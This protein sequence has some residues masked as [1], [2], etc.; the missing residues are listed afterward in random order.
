ME[1]EVGGG[2]LEGVSVGADEDV[3]GKGLEDGLVASMTEI[4]PKVVN[5]YFIWF[6][7]HL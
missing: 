1:G 5:Q 4:N 6:A 3:T 7:H 2:T